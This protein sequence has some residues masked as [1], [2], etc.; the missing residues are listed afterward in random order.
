MYKLSA[1]EKEL[2]AVLKHR[3][4]KHTCLGLMFVLRESDSNYQ[5]MLRYLEGNPYASQTDI[6]QEH[7]RILGQPLYQLKSRHVLA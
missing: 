2:I 1:V 6:M 3:V 5:K 4:D 7:R